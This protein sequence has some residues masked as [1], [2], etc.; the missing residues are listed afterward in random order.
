[1]VLDVEVL[2]KREQLYLLDCIK[3]QAAYI[4]CV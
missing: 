3:K 4:A 2:T 1:M